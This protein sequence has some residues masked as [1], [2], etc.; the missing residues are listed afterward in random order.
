[1]PSGDG[2]ARRSHAGYVQHRPLAGHFLPL[3]PLAWALRAAGHEVLVTTPDNFVPAVLGSGLPAASCGPSAEFTGLIRREDLPAVREGLV[4]Q[5]YLH[6]RAFGRI[7]AGSLVAASWN[8][9][10]VQYHW[11]VA[12]L[13]ECRHAASGSCRGPPQSSTPG[14]PVCVSGTRQSTGRSVMS[15]PTATPEHPAGS[16]DGGSRGPASR[17]ARFSRSTATAACSV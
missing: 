1:M 17:S 9:P 3:A 2:A 10:W 7:A 15:R 8:V 12:E 14:R 16:S 13:P 4:P 11:S 5:R 6:R